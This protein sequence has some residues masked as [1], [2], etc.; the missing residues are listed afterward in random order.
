MFVNFILFGKDKGNK[1]EIN[2][3]VKDPT[4]SIGDVTVA[5]KETTANSDSI[6]FTTSKTEVINHEPTIN[7]DVIHAGFKE[8]NIGLPEDNR[9]KILD[10]VKS[11]EPET[12][13]LGI[14]KPVEKTENLTKPELMDH[15][16]P[17][18]GL[19]EG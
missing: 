16:E 17:K 11:N 6:V 4:T 18:G 7:Y 15:P 8:P 3:G 14:S 5:G 13:D 12:L 2:S 19:L 10:Q 1:Y 9:K